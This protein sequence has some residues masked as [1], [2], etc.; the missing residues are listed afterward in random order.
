MSRSVTALF[1]L[2]FAACDQPPQE[3]ER[4]TQAETTLP[5]CASTCDVTKSCTAG[6]SVN[7][8]QGAVATI[9]EVYM[10]GNC[11]GKGELTPLPPDKDTST[12]GGSSGGGAHA[13]TPDIGCHDYG[14]RKLVGQTNYRYNLATK[15]RP[16]AGWV[17]RVYNTYAQPQIN[18]RQRGLA[19]CFPERCSCDRIYQLNGSLPPAA[20]WGLQQ[21]DIGICRQF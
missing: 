16:N 14:N 5:S 17:T 1:F 6:C 9:C 12:G 10:A 21:A 19:P 18:A 7:D 15:A 8:S 3:I 4:P 11:D 13:C 20:S 2:T